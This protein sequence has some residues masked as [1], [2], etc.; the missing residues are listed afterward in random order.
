[1]L[2]SLEGRRGIVRAKPPLPAV[3]GLFGQPTLVQN[4]LTFAA[5]PGILA[6]GAAAYRALGVGRS[7]GPMPFQLA[8]NI[9]HGGLVE[10]PFGVTLRTL[11]FDFGGGTASGR[12]VKAIQVGGPLGCYVPESRWDEPLDYERYAA[13]GAGIG[14]GGLVVHDDT[15]DLSRLARYAMEFCAKESCGKCT[16]C[17]IGSTRGVELIDRIRSETRPAEQAA[18]VE[19]LRDL[20]TTMIDASLCA[21]GGMTPLP[22][23]SAL[24]NHPEDFGLS[25]GGAA[26]QQGKP[27]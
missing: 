16:P 7:T 8:G 15:A 24:E 1:M 23:L 20:C 4:V 22:V 27:A 13:F 2:E 14:H 12:T 11:V 17:R 9:R 10:V 25:A 26:A 18:Q 19:L 6:D 5:V 21:M 3:K